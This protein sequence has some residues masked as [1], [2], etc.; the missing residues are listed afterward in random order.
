[1]FKWGSPEHRALMRIKTNTFMAN[2]AI[3]DLLK[4]SKRRRTE[5]EKAHQS[6]IRA[7]KMPSNMAF[8]GLNY[9]NV[10]R[11][12]YENSKGTMYFRSKWEANY[13]LYLDFLVKQKQIKSWEFE[14]EFFI[15]DKIKY[16]TTRYLPDFKITNLDGSLEYHEVKGYMDSRS[17]TKLRRMK[18]Y[19]P[20]IKLILVE[21]E[22]YN[23]IKKK[24]GRMLNFY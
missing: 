16:G 21:K 22:S 11:G 23:S 12:D 24:V 14:A 8:G 10:Q 18:R 5:A 4:V 2:P 20:K 7:G 1:M 17:K 6:K 3:H 9:P 13:A 19:Y 15:F